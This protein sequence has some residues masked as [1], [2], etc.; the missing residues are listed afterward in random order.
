MITVPIT[1]SPIPA[2][3]KTIEDVSRRLE[4]AAA[5]VVLGPACSDGDT[6]GGAERAAMIIEG[7]AEALGVIDVLGL[8]VA[9]IGVGAGAGDSCAGEG[10]GEAHTGI[11]RC[12]VTSLPPPLTVIV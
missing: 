8:A 1:T 9:L 6:S 2:V 11:C 4:L 10:A 3:Q 5:R 7:L 12:S